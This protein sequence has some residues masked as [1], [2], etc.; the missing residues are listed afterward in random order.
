MSADDAVRR[1]YEVFPYP[2]R[3]PRDESKRLV[4][5][6]PS[7]LDEIVHYLFA[8]SIGHL[9]PFRVLVAGGGTGDGL[10]MLA[11]ECRNADI[12]VEI[13]YLDISTA[14]RGIAEARAQARGLDSITFHTGSLLAIGDIAPGPYHYI[15][16]VGVLHHL[17]DPLAGLTALTTQLS[18]DGGMGLMVYGTHGR[19]GVYPMQA[20]LRTLTDGLQPA[21]KVG[22][23]KRLIRSLPPTNWFARNP[24]LADH[25][26]SDAGLYD[27]LL[28][29]QD[30]AFTVPELLDLLARAGLEVASFIE[31]VRYRAETYVHD[32]KLR[33][34]I[35]A[36]DWKDSAELAESLAGNMK[37]HVVYAAPANRREDTVAQPDNATLKPVLHR[38]DGE[39]FARTFRPGRVVDAEYDGIKVSL[40]LP[41]LTGALLPRVDGNTSLTDL[42]GQLSRTRRE[43]LPWETFRRQFQ[44]IYTLLNGINRML[45]RR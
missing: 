45:L 26:R 41:P 2:A 19:T 22:M 10:I 35:E 7:G 27:L 14:S 11:Q 24:L 20:A 33:G 36:L 5:G 3:D 25:R 12:P 37:T 34:R 31:P 40:A 39:A 17:P 1:Q 6:S 23:A 8:G 30:R 44:Q 16:C 15:D 38:M 9:R 4:E 18:P 32:P 42:H 21:D 13:H 28:H 43:G 29:D